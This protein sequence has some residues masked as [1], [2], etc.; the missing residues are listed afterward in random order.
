MDAL[1]QI[2]LDVV[3]RNKRHL[4]DEEIWDRINE[5]ICGHIRSCLTKEVKYLVKDEEC[6]QLESVRESSGCIWVLR[7][8][9]FFTQI[10]T[11]IIVNNKI[12]FLLLPWT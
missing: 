11:Q 4:Y 12:I 10:C 3:M 5:K 2:D 6:E 9:D 7:K 1:I 8:W